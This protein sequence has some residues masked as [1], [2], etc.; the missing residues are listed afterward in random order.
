MK[1]LFSVLTASLLIVFTSSCQKTS[2][3]VGSRQN[4]NQTY[5]TMSLNQLNDFA[6]LFSKID[7]DLEKP[8][9]T[10]LTEIGKSR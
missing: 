7:V 6:E 3:L 5:V 2:S 1:H 9:L 8:G 4:T 10:L